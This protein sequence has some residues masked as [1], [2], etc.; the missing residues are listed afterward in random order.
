MKILTR[1]DII[2]IHEMLAN[3]TGGSRG[4]KDE[5]LLD[6]ALQAPYQTYAGEDLYN[7]LVSKAA[8]LGHGI[9]NNHPFVDG[10]K[11]VGV[12]TMLTF[13]EINGFRM[14]LTDNELIELTINLA[15]GSLSLENLDYYINKAGSFKEV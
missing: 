6:S 15:N 12:L 4:L 9:I 1:D 14:K 10:N 3:E 8:K 11:R 2:Q 13:L 7:G 5:A